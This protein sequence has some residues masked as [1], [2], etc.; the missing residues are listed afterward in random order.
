MDSTLLPTAS[1]LKGFQQDVQHRAIRLQREA[2]EQERQLAR[3]QAAAQAEALASQ[4]LVR[5]Y[6]VNT[7]PVNTEP[8]DLTSTEAFPAVSQTQPSHTEN[9]SST[10]TSPQ[11]NIRN[12]W[13]AGPPTPIEQFPSLS[14][15]ASAQRPTPSGDWSSPLR[16][17]TSSAATPKRPAPQGSPNNNS[18]TKGKKRVLLSTDMLM[19]K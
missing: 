10:P 3:S 9:A 14:A 18:K 8:L 7:R 2:E 19:H 17:N 13:R 1:N 6:L 5:A 12:E 15:A 16:A 4:Q 11:R